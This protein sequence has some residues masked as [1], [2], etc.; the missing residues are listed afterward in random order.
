MSIRTCEAREAARL[1]TVGEQE[2]AA[3]V[4]AQRFAQCA[5]RE[6]AAQRIDWDI[7]GA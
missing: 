4:R 5:K 2:Q 3:S 6:V 7:S 1:T